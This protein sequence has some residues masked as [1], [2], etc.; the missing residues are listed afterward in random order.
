[1][2]IWDAK[3]ERKKGL[4]KS[5]T[6]RRKRLKFLE[7]PERK[8]DGEIFR[9]KGRRKIDGNLTE[10]TRREMGIG[11]WE[12]LGDDGCV[13]EVRMSE[14]CMHKPAPFYRRISLGFG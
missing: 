8:K 4:Q 3:K 7:E 14:I 13:N 2:Q 1:M 10:K 9:E 12:S 6:K 5:R 11:D